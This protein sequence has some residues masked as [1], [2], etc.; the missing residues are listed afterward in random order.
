MG[1]VALH[2][3]IFQPDPTCQVAFRC[4]VCGVQNVCSGDRIGRETASCDGCGSTVRMRS[5]IHLLSTALWGRSMPLPEFPQDKGI[6]GKGLSDW[7]GYADRLAEKFSYTNTFYHQEPRLDIENVTE[8]EK[9][10]C[11]FLISTDVFEHTLGPA[12]KAFVGAY[13]LLKP[14]GSL[15]FTVP[16][17]LEAETVEH[18]PQLTDFTI[19]TL[20]GKYFVVGQ[21]AAGAYEL[22]QEP[23]F[24]GGPGQT[25]EMR[26]F[27]R[28][29]V[30][31]HLRDAGFTD[32]LVLERSEPEC[33][34]LL[35]ESWSLPILARKPL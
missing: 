15:I 24:H 35:T 13:E 28:K 2:N 4:N 22:Y 27:C 21:T 20:G 26:V 10:T 1:D 17:T 7:I 19:A 31:A 23:V 8:E 32:I 3:G 30:E 25:L 29:A 5:I 14:G 12:L 34:V 11:D 16:F 18:Y 33:G 9:G 6:V